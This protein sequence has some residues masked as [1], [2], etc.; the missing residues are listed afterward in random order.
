MTKIIIVEKK[1]KIRKDIAQ[2]DKEICTK[3]QISIINQLYLD[4]IFK[5][6]KDVI[7]ALKK[8]LSS[9]KVQDKKYQRYNKTAFITYEKLI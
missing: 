3:N 7:R 8:K 2:L 4:E 6:Q 1:S 9:Y 5:G